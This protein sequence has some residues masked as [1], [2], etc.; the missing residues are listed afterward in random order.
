M[1][2]LNLQLRENPLVDFDEIHQNPQNT[3]FDPQTRKALDLY[4]DS[5]RYKIVNM[6]KNTP[7]NFKIYIRDNNSN[8][9]ALNRGDLKNLNSIVKIDSETALGIDPQYADHMGDISRH[10][11]DSDY[12]KLQDPNAIVVILTH[13][14]GANSIALSP[15]IMAHRVAHSLIEQHNPFHKLLNTMIA[16]W[17]SL[18]LIINSLYLYFTTIPQAKT[19]QAQL[20]R[21]LASTTNEL[22]L[23]TYFGNTE[24]LRKQKQQDIYGEIFVELLTQYIVRGHIDT[25]ELPFM[26]MLNKLYLNKKHGALYDRYLNLQI[27]IDNIFEELNDICQKILSNSVGKVFVL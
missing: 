18:E 25:K 23:L 19:I 20:K 6:F 13:N 24:S 9:L 22:M 12:K 21:F 3:S 5:R 7:W 11:H 8:P 14:E 4:L 1:R 27:Y 2:F 26:T 17:S 15:W 10:L 16:L